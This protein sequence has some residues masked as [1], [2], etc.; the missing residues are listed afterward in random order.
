LQ[1]KNNITND[2]KAE[3]F[4]RLNEL[5]TRAVTKMLH[6]SVNFQPREKLTK[7]ELSAIA[8]RYM[9]GLKMQKHPYL[10]YQHN[11]ANHPHIHIVT[12]LVRSD[13][14]RVDTHHMGRRLS[15]PTCKAIEQEFHLL[16][17]KSPKQAPV[18]PPE[19]VRKFAPGDPTPVSQSVERIVASVNKHYHFS[20]LNE[21][22]AILRAYNVT[23]E[24]GNPGTKT[25]RYGGIYY[26][27]LDDQGNKVCPPIMASRLPS[28][29]TLPRLQDK[30]LHPDPRHLDHLASIRHRINWALDQQQAN[31]RQFV[32]RLQRDGIEIVMPPANGRNTHDQIY[33]DHRTHTT[34]SGDTLGP[35]YTTEAVAKAIGNAQQADLV[36]RHSA[37]LKHAPHFNASVPQLL[38]AVLKTGPGDPGANDF[39]L[40]QHLGPRHKL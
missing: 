20:N 3:R 33:V 9:E 26:V 21:Y 17:S 37:E 32:A 36:S 25:R 39:G 5:N 8:D 35:G 38:S 16:P 23:A 40:D 6:I 2:D 12:S 27:A 30:F 4:Q 19:E 18:L 11:D 1:S 34:V 24:T 29:P 13:G 31:L 14:T 22:N 10:V 28:R 7:D 15:A